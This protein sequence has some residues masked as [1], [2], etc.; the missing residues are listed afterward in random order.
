[1]RKVCI[2]IPG[3]PK[4]KGR[5]RFARGRA[6]TPRSTLDYEQRVGE[7]ARQK[8]KDPTG[9]DVQVDI[10]AVY[11][12]PKSWPKARREAARVGDVLPKKPDIDNVIKIVLDGLNGAAFVDDS[13]VHMVSAEK[14][15]GDEPRVEI[16]LNF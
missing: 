11:Q 6:Y 3:Q 2:T 9:R 16:E 12:I 4:A 10:L 1:M 5:P 14:A 15:Y 13:Q 8:I 7:A